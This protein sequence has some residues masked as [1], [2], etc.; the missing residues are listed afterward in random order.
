MLNGNNSLIVWQINL[1]TKYFARRW[2]ERWA[3]KFHDEHSHLARAA[4]LEM[5]VETWWP[6]NEGLFDFRDLSKVVL[7]TPRLGE[8]G[9]THWSMGFVFRMCDRADEEDLKL[10]IIE[11]RQQYR[12]AV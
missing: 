7:S 3:Q 10:K 1:L 2:Q 8:E 12:A 11:L 4:G 6:G 5:R 9:Q